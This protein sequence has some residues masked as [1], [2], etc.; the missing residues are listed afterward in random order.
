MRLL[1]FSQRNKEA[2]EQH[3]EVSLQRVAITGICYLNVFPQL[4]ARQIGEGSLILQ[5]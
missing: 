1:I 4:G 5:I 2:E 3:I